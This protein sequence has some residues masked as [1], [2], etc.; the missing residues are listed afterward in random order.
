[1]VRPETQIK[2][3]G[4]WRRESNCM[5]LSHI[6]DILV[7]FIKYV[8]TCFCGNTL[9]KNCQSSTVLQHVCTDA[10]IKVQIFHK[11]STWAKLHRDVKNTL[12]L[13]FK[14]LKRWSG[15]VSLQ[16]CSWTIAAVY[17]TL[18]H[19]FNVGF[20]KSKCFEQRLGTPL[21]VKSDK[22][23]AEYRLSKVLQ[24]SVYITEFWSKSQFNLSFTGKLN[25]GESG[26]LEC[27][28][29]HT[30]DVRVKAADVER[31]APVSVWFWVDSVEVVMDRAAGS[32]RGL[33]MDGDSA[34]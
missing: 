14:I 30:A 13:M 11:T 16:R 25:F 17:L 10:C 3:R 34:P 26:S 4:F 24:S 18:W 22:P 20:F 1:M 2:W 6:K 31:A 21:N 5:L 33:V 7:K 28:S 9:V 8:A 29:Y 27:V 15:T 23:S 32:D 12:V 19:R